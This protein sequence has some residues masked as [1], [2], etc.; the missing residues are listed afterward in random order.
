MADPT[1]RTIRVNAASRAYDVHIGASALAPVADAVCAAGPHTPRAVHIFVDSGLSAAQAALVI[2]PLSRAELRVS[3]TAITPTEED[4]SLQTVHRMLQDLTRARLERRDVVI[5]LGGGIVGDLAGFA[6]AT[7]RRGVAWINCPTTLLSM[8]D[9]SVGGKTGANVR[10]GAELK[11][12]MV[13][14]FWQP[15]LV[16]ADIRLL[17]TLS[18]RTFR[19]GLAECIKH[20]LLSGDFGDAELLH[21]TKSNLGAILQRD[22][23]VLTELVARNVAVK[24]AV[25]G[26]DEREEADD[27][28]GGAGGRAL[29]NLGHTFGHA[30]ETLPKVSPTAL[31]SDAPLQHGEAV[32][33]GL[34]CAA[35]AAELLKLMPTGLVDE[36]RTLLAH[37]GLPTKAHGLAEKHTAADVLAAMG[38]DKKASGGKMR[39]VLP[40]G[41]GRCKVVADAPR[42]SIL[43]A[44]EA[45][46]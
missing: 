42:E 11:K 35:R 26:D 31:A 14:A 27:A 29:L 24:A 4:K 17:G 41:E 21:W 28:R 40:C 6:A 20:G 34:I 15:S 32:A 36:V 1:H 33:L 18:D 12:N 39:L 10:I 30:I 23:A 19:A 38:D 16:L 9:A 25:V 7:Y 45:I 43:T 37:A 2:E 3:T 13:G 8:V 44:I 5:A 22:T 46:R